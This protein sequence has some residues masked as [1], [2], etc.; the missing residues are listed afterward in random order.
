[1]TSK[2]PDGRDE[3]RMAEP[4]PADPSTDESAEEQAVSED[5]DR[6][7]DD[8]RRERDSY[9]EVAQRAKADFENYRK[10]AAR[11]VTEAERRGKASLARQLVPAIDNLERAL[12][13]A[14]AD[15]AS[16]APGEI[17]DASGEEASAHE[18]LVR[19]VALVLGELQA[20]LERAG[21]EAYDPVGE[22]F[23]PSWH[24]ALQTR[25]VDGTEAGIVIE[26]LER[27][28]RLDGQVLRAARVVVSE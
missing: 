18:A 2:E 13:A 11:E 17:S 8:V 6:L 5:L 16:G 10:R 26:T 28:Y 25:S 1:M 20:T 14:G 19:G 24:E 23:D 12:R 9:L 4:S 27:G 21:V 15:P 3:S 7:L 22:P